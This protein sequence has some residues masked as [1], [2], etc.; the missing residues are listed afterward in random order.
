MDCSRNY[1]VITEAQ[2]LGWSPFDVCSDNIL[3]ERISCLHPNYQ[4][5]LCPPPFG[6]NKLSQMLPI[7]EA[8]PERHVES[9][10]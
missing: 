6:A 9:M 1:S 5:H 2:V 10:A 8:P 4:C 7:R 3:A